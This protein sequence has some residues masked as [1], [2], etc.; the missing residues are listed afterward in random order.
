M[1]YLVC[2]LN[3]LMS[4]HKGKDSR[5]A[6][7]VPPFPSNQGF[8]SPSITEG[9]SN[10]FIMTLPTQGVFIPPYAYRTGMLITY[11]LIGNSIY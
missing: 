11:F 8:L 1:L 10:F 6:S 3:V 7:A 4:C 5:R 2:M 9:P